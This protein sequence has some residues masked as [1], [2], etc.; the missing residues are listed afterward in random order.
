MIIIDILNPTKIALGWNGGLSSIP[1]VALLSILCDCG[2]IFVTTVASFFFFKLT[3]N[4]NITFPDLTLMLGMQIFWTGMTRVLSI[5]VM[6][7]GLY[8]LKGFV[9]LIALFSYICT[10]ILIIAKYKTM[11]NWEE[12]IIAMRTLITRKQ[13]ELQERIDDLESFGKKK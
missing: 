13:A 6:F 3:L 9:D 4:K 10:C 7:Y 5:T 2:I 12:A 11:I 1:F 8:Y